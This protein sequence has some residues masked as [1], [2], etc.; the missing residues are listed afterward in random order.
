MKTILAERRVEEP[1][2]LPQHLLG[3]S[4]PALERWDDIEVWEREYR[5]RPLSRMPV[6]FLNEELPAEP[7]AAYHYGMV[8][9]RGQG[10]ER[11]NRLIFLLHGLNERSWDKYLPWARRL[12]LSSGATVLLY[13]MAF[14]MNRSPGI[15]SNIDEVFRIYRERKAI[16]GPSGA[17]SHANAVLSSRLEKRPYRFFTSGLQSY[18]DIADITRWIRAGQNPDVG[19]GASVD[20]FGYSIGAFLAEM[21][22]MSNPCGLFSDSRLFAFCGGSVMD[23]AR[24]RSR[25]ILDS[26]GE[27][28]L[29]RL[30]RSLTKGDWRI[31]GPDELVTEDEWRYFLSMLSMDSMAD[32][33]RKRLDEIGDR[34]SGIAL[35]K[36]EVFPF[37]GVRDTLGN[38]VSLMDFPFAYRHESPFSAA[39]AGPEASALAM[40]GVFSRASAFLGL[41]S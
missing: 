9:A 7:A 19:P 12:A 11:S 17:S 38:R 37:Q 15:C 20:F 31:D 2:P 5:S 21:L 26:G 41:A 6:A 10:A 22:L 32:V 36:D 39:D 18:R 28:A 29:T 14:H 27:T 3:P 35:K 24:A 4:L 25:A 13:P 40:A 16:L 1:H 34:I 23:A 33:R 30:F 8:R